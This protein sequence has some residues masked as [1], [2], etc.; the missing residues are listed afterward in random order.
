MPIEGPELPYP[1][2][3]GPGPG[4]PTVMRR[5]PLPGPSVARTAICS[6]LNPAIRGGVSDVASAMVQSLMPGMQ[7]LGHLGRS[8]MTEAQLQQQMREQPAAL[9][10]PP[11]MTPFQQR[12][13]WFR[14]NPPI[15][16][17][18]ADAGA[19]RGRNPFP[20][21]YPFRPTLPPPPTPP[22]TPDSYPRPTPG[23]LRYRVTGENSSTI[24]GR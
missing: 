24:S 15:P 18:Y 10:G 20:N 5:L 8:A 4:T 1:P 14:E 16:Q 6:A 13:E 21:P 9:F 12:G 7:R 2:G 19:E 3:Y 11:D 23:P 22:P 17:P